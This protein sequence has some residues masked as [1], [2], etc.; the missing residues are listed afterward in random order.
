M[1]ALFSEVAQSAEQV[2]LEHKVKGS[3]PFLA[4]QSEVCP[5]A[6]FFVVVYLPGLPPGRL[7]IRHQVIVESQ[8]AAQGLMQVIDWQYRTRLLPQ[9]RIVIE[10]AI[11]DICEAKTADQLPVI[12]IDRNITAPGIQQFRQMHRHILSA[13]PVYTFR[14]WMTLL[15]RAGGHA[16][17]VYLYFPDGLPL[18]K[19]GREQIKVEADEL[20]QE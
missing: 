5:W 20:T 17:Q 7:A 14:S 18:F 11:H 6:D 3:N 10:I 1:P 15:G 12:I 2:P 8:N 13:V 9:N 4:E 19:T 16:D